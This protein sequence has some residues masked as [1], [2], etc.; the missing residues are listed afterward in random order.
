MSR[1]DADLEFV[2]RWHRG[3]DQFDVSLAYDEPGHPFDRRDLVDDPVTIDTERLGLVVDDEPE[4]GAM[5]SAMLFASE[6]TRTFFAESR[7]VVE[8]KG[9]P[10]HVRLSVDPR[11]PRRFHAVRWESLRDPG[12]GK[13]SGVHQGGVR[14]PR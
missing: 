10:L 8:D 14:R 9:L 3:T 13:R 7:A 5:L 1:Q 6:Q 4:Y 12:D 11:A 2:L